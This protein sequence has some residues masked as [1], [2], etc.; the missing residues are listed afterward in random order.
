M[1]VRRLVRLFQIRLSKLKQIFLTRIC[2]KSVGGLPGMLLTLQDLGAKDIRVHGPASSS[3]YFEGFRTFYNRTRP[4]CKLQ[5]AL[6][7]LAVPSCGGHSSYMG[8]AVEE[9]SLKEV[10]CVFIY[11]GTVTQKSELAS[12]SSFCAIGHLCRRILIH[13]NDKVDQAR[14]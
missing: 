10:T 8:G 2:G 14:L 1:H 6:G 9:G 5:T 3:R 12:P 7:D 13:R 4:I 11:V